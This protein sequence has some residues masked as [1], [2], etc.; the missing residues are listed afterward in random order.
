M[1]S[2]GKAQ[3]APFGD[4]FRV[5]QVL[6]VVAGSPL[7]EDA[8]WLDMASV[9]SI[10]AA[11]SKEKTITLTWLS[12]LLIHRTPLNSRQFVMDGEVFDPV[13]LMDRVARTVRECWPDIAI[14][15][16]AKVRVA[17]NHMIRADVSYPPKRLLGAAGSIRLEF[18]GSVGDWALPLLLSGLVGVGKARNMGQGR[19]SVEGF[20]IHPSWPPLPAKTLLERAATPENLERSWK[21]MLKAGPRPGVDNLG[22]EEFQDALTEMLPEVNTDLSGG[23]VEP[24]ALCGRI[25]QEKEND[26]EELGQSGKRAWSFNYN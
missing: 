12:P 23:T 2:F 10:A 26:R 14:P 15:E 7:R 22:P 16:S 25:I 18:G 11:L 3:G 24:D 20:P 6:D 19:F 21:A 13:K 1:T 5:E 8:I 4:N 9:Q 17:E